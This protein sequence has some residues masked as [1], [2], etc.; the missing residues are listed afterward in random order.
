[1]PY[2]ITAIAFHPGAPETYPPGRKLRCFGFF[3]TLERAIASV[4]ENECDMHECLYN[5][6]VVENLDEGIHP[7][8]RKDNP[9]ELWF[10]W[11]RDRE[12]WIQTQKP[13]WSKGYLGWSIG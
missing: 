13:D 6:I 5:Y 9:E 8:V 7:S 3:G 12:R 11:S 1:M 2:F 10:E 4:L